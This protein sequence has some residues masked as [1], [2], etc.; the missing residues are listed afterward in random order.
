MHRLE[1]D[2]NDEI[3]HLKLDYENQISELQRN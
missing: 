1:Q 3:K 2:K